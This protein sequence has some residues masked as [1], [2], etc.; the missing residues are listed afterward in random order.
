VKTKD[1]RINLSLDKVYEKKTLLVSL[2]LVIIVICYFLAF[3][4]RFEI[5]LT[6]VQLKIMLSTLPVIVL[7][8]ITCFWLFGLY[9]GMWRFA[10]TSDL[11]SILKAI[12]TSSVFII[13]SLYFLNRFSGYPRSIFFIDWLLLMICVGGSRFSIRL[14]GEIVSSSR[15]TG[16]R[17]LIVGAGSAGEVIARE[18]LKN[19]SLYYNLVGFID[20]DPVKKGLEIHGKRILGNKEDIPNIVKK[21]D[22][23]EIIICIPSGTSVQI[24]E[25]VDQC[26]KSKIGFKTVPALAEII[27][28]KPHISQIRQVQM[29]DLLGREEL[30]I[31]LDEVR[32]EFSARRVLVTGGGGSIGR[33]LCRQI[34]RFN[35]ELLILF[36]RGENSVFYTERELR[37]EFPSLDCAPIVADV[38]DKKSVD[39]ILG[40]YR[41]HVIFHAAAYKHVPLMEINAA[42]VFKNNV[43]GTKIVAD[44]AIKHGVDKFIFISTDKAVKPKSFM[45]ATKRTGELYVA[46]LSKANSTRFMTV[47][48]GNVLGS[49][50]SVAR[51]FKEQ[52]QQGGPVTITH[53]KA[54]RYLM[55]IPEAVLLILQAASLGQG[56]ELFVL[57]M[58]KP[59]NIMELA[60][61]MIR[62]SGLEPEKDIPIIITGLRPGEKLT[63][64]LY[65]P[66]TERLMATRYKNINRVEIINGIDY[67]AVREAICGLEVSVQKL[68]QKAIIAEFK[69]FLQPKGAT[70]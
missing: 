58:G 47:R 23:E 15:K 54:S 6:Q 66:E 22:I 57:D 38:S 8:R 48:F 18:M 29:E 52:I 39:Q 35:P 28:G 21:Y 2:D 68:D 33:E 34:A 61:T 4:F 70:I 45:G 65:D 64:E 1:N 42:E 14:L 30:D 3:V 63:E 32:G 9:K 16:R 7:F 59:I 5:Q 17:V 51:L 26:M 37:Q 20:D 19:K 55:T 53:P 50:G 62:L 40:T 25:I 24:K 49:T 10:S 67:R 44:L 11:I 69:K 31:N 12:S 36:D 41:P 27:N 43:L 56:G 60:R 46:S 13:L